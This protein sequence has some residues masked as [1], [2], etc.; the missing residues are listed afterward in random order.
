MR[1]KS[2]TLTRPGPNSTA[3]GHANDGT[4]H[5]TVRELGSASASRKHFS[6]IGLHV[7]ISEG[8]PDIIVL[9]GSRVLL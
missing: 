6:Q 1:Q 9:K 2:G 7:I 3:F 4:Q 8:E 5:C